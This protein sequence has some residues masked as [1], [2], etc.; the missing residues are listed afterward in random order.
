[1]KILLQRLIAVTSLFF[2]SSVAAQTRR[3]NRV[4]QQTN[5]E[6]EKRRS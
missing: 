4:R 1:M 2:L 5:V 6:L 3:W